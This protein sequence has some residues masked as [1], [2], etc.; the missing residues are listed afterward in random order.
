MRAELSALQHSRDAVMI[1][2]THYQIK[3]IPMTHRIVALNR[4][5]I[6][7]IFSPL[8]RDFPSARGFDDTFFGLNFAP[9]GVPVFEN[10]GP[11]MRRLAAPPLAA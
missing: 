9:S 4:G 7:Q 6:E 1:W 11:V 8:G 3:A 5:L 2:V 10:S